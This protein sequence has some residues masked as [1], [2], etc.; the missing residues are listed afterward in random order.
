[1]T[2]LISVYCL[3]Y[4]NI[5]GSGFIGCV[6]NLSVQSKFSTGKIQ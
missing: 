6:L 2:G 5:G 3:L 1:V 4:I